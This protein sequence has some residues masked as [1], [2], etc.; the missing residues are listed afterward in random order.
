MNNMEERAKFLGLALKIARLK[1]RK[2]QQELASE[3][4]ISG[5]Y[6]SQVESGTKIPSLLLL[7]EICDYLE[8]TIAELFGQAEL[9]N[10]KE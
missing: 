9:L 2:Q 8:T 10:Y 7:W 6:L 3:I 5:P 1:R 4:G